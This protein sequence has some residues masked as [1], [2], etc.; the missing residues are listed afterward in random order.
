V[1]VPSSVGAGNAGKEVTIIVHREK[2]KEE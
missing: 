2:A 1:G